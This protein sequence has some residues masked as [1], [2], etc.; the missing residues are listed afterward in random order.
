MTGTNL[1]A[2]HGSAFFGAIALVRRKQLKIREALARRKRYIKTL[3]ELSAL[4][5]RN[6]WDLGIPRSDIRRLAWETA[7][8]R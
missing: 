5:N 4:S 3:D 8:D 1:V 6:L 7:Y 2:G